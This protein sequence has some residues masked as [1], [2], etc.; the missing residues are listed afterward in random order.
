ME[1]YRLINEYDGN[2]TIEFQVEEG[3]DPCSKA[4]EVLGWSLVIAKEV[5][6]ENE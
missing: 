1:T 3:E 6:D 4:L 2:D 5:E